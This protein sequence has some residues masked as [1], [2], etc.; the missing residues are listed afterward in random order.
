MEEVTTGFDIREWIE[1]H[2][3]EWFNNDDSGGI[4]VSYQDNCY[5]IEHR[6]GQSALIEVKVLR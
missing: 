3:L 1:E 6:S 5:Y 4:T 2:M